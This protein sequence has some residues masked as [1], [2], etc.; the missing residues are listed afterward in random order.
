MVRDH[1][2]ILPLVMAADIVGFSALTFGRHFIQG[3]GV[4]FDVKPVAD[5]LPVAVYRQRFA[6]QR[7][8]NS[9]RDQFFREVVRP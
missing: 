4:I 3:A 9:Q 1:I 2:N 7:I 6:G 8:E 5:L